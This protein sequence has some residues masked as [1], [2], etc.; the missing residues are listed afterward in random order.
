MDISNMTGVIQYSLL[1]CLLVHR[2]SQQSRPV[3]PLADRI[4]IFGIHE[5]PNGADNSH[6]GSPRIS[7]WLSKDR[8]SSRLNAEIACARENWNDRPCLST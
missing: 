2:F 1:I 4:P 5:Q 8:A 6:D 3:P 7:L